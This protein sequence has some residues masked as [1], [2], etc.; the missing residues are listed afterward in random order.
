M[1]KSVESATSE[2]IKEVF[3]VSQNGE[4]FSTKVT[5]LKEIID[6]SLKVQFWKR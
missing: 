5:I 4:R 1:A 6:N 3:E 2:K